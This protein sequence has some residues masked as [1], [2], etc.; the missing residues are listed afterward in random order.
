MQRH[1]ETYGGWYI[2]II[3]WGVVVLAILLV[4]GW[5]ALA[6]WVGGDAD[7][8]NAPAVCGGRPC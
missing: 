4:G 6:A 5:D 3:F 2:N 7:A 1:L 8:G